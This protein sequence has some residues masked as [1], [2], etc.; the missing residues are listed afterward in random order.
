MVSNSIILVGVTQPVAPQ[1]RTVYCVERE[2]PGKDEMVVNGQVGDWPS[3]SVMF[4]RHCLR[5]SQCARR[6][7]PFSPFLSPHSQRHSTFPS[8]FVLFSPI[9]RLLRGSTSLPLPK[10]MLG[11]AGAGPLQYFRG[12][13]LSTISLFVVLTFKNLFQTRPWL[14]YFDAL[15]QPSLS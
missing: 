4:A 14:S 7:R 8:F 1:N 6:R 12:A 9:S 11:P 2:R 15:H 5:C 13:R 10:G 3:Y